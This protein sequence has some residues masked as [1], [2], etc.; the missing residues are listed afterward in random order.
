[1]SDAP[2]SIFVGTSGWSYEDWQGIVYPTHPRI[3]DQLHYLAS[4]LDALEVNTSFYRTPPPKMTAGWVRRIAHLPRFR[5]T[6]KL[7]RR[8]THERSPWA[9]AE[10]QEFRDGLAPVAEAGR[11]GAVLLQFP[12]S[13]R[14]EE[15]SYGWLSHLAD[16]LRPWPLAIE[17]RH[18]SWLTDEG[19]YCLELLRLSMADIDQPALNHCIRPGDV[20][21][22]P[23]GYVRLH[24]RRKDAWF[25]ANVAPHER[26][27][28][29]Y[30]D[31]EIDEWIGR[32]REI[33]KKSKELYVFTNN[34]Y[35]GQAPANA[36]QI[37]AKLKGRR[38]PVPEPMIPYFPFL[39]ELALPP[40]SLPGEQG[41]L[42]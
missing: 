36:F 34:H 42:F 2:A 28:Y 4:Y 21:T 39:Q 31:D 25:A 41:R 8:F 3:H 1:M 22:G 29:L 24:G 11:L 23:L 30:R 6:F 19:R 40:D 33:S 7:N 32:I 27:N 12:W 18:D 14:A 20:V 5:F 38:I 15:E 13:F 35:R 17:V 26:Y 16:A 37:L 9:P 10:M